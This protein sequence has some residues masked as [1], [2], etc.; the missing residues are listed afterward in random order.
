VLGWA[1]GGGNNVLPEDVGL[2]LDYEWLYLQVHYYNPAG[3]EGLQDRS[4]VAICSTPTPRTHAAGVLAFGTIEIDVP[5]RARDHVEAYTCPGYVFSYLGDFTIL[6]SSPHMHTHGTR[7]LSEVVRSDGSRVE[8]SRV[9]NWDFNN[10]TSFPRDPPI[11]IR[12]GDGVRVTCTYNNPSDRAVRFGENTDDEMCFDFMLVY[13]I[14]NWPAD[15]PR[16][17]VN[18]ERFL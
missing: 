8:I 10:Q 4:G 14:T 3:E 2:V 1:P 6:G 16:F 17:C 15:T 12:G 9:D 11:T 7:F 13:P 5:A 18:I